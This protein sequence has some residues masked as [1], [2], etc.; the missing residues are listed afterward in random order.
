LPQKSSSF[1]HHIQHSLVQARGIERQSLVSFSNFSFIMQRRHATSSTPSFG[2]PNLSNHSG[3]FHRRSNPGNALSSMTGSSNS[4]DRDRCFLFLAAI[5]ILSIL[6]FT[7]EIYTDKTPSSLHIAVN[8]PHLKAQN[9]KMKPTSIDAT[10]AMLEQP[11]SFVDGEKMLKKRLK[12]LQER[13]Q[14]GVDV[15]VKHLTRWQGKDVPVWIPKDGKPLDFDDDIVDAAKS[16]SFEDIPEVKEADIQ[17]GVLDSFPYPTDMIDLGA[18]IH[19]RPS[20]GIHRASQDAVFGLAE[21]YDL[22]T[23]VAFI[24]TLRETGFSG[25]IV[26][27]VSSPENMKAGVEHY[28]RQQQNLVIYMM[29]WTC[30]NGKGE[31]KATAGEGVNLCQANGIYQH[32]D[33]SPADDPRDPRPVA[34]SRYE[35]YW[36]WAE[37][38]MQSSMIMLIDSRDTFFQSNPFSTIERSG[39]DIEETGGLLHFFGVSQFRM[40]LEVPKLFLFCGGCSII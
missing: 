15:G 39:K 20:Y 9:I 6:S 1:H 19:L 28:L 34:T 21:G 17:E 2:Q 25:D 38:Y 8:K 13:Q 16:I 3:N 40:I 35:L 12:V 24:E 5:V 32:S 10:K 26:L 27:S 4:Q 18:G 23:Y 37:Q 31:S 22:N 33:G 14:N 36:I 11:S 29:E 30:F 7:Y